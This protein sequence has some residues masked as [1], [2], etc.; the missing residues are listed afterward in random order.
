[1][2][3]VVVVG[4]TFGAGKTTYCDVLGKKHGF[5]HFDS[6]CFV[7]GYDPVADAGKT[8]TGADQKN[9]AEKV[10]E[11]TK[12]RFEYRAERERA[13][14]SGDTPDVQRM[15]GLFKAIVAKIE[16]VRRANPEKD[17]LVPRPV[18]FREE[19]DI[20]R[21]LLGE[22]FACVMICC[23]NDVLA[24]RRLRRLKNQASEKGV[25]IHEFVMTFPEGI[26]QGN[27][28]EEKIEFMMVNT[29]APAVRAGESDEPYVYTV[30][31]TKE[32]TTDDILNDTA[33]FLGLKA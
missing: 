22:D 6:D 5:V 29:S 25:T 21:S 20:F 31:V 17:I 27:T 30:H 33:A 7:L 14:Q 2:G 24:E 9:A 13:L 12:L 3:R 1:M 23:S 26:L 10:P 32:T 11:L 16:E 15:V 18:F 28:P 4:G 8:L 19:R